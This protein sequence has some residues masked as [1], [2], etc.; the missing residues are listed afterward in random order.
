MKRLILIIG[1]LLIGLMGFICMP[2]IITLWLLGAYKPYKL[3][4]IYANLTT[5]PEK[6]PELKE[7]IED[8][9]V[10]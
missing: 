3:F 2:I 6:Y 10:K 9:E 5:F 4:E 1:I 8:W 7:M